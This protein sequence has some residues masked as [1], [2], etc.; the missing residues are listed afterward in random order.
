MNKK[1]KYLGIILCLSLVCAT[2][3]TTKV[4]ANNY[5]TGDVNLSLDFGTIAE[6]FTIDSVT[7]GWKLEWYN[8]FWYDC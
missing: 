5:G 2:I 4:F 7:V 1:F 6:E 3:F 8:Y